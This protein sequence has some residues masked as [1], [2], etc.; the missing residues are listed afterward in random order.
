LSRRLK[1]SHARAHDERDFS[2][3]AKTHLPKKR[4]T[5]NIVELKD[6]RQPKKI[7]LLPKNLAQESYIDALEDTSKHI[8]FAAGPAGT[9]KTMLATLAGIDQLQKN[10]ISKIIITRPAVSVDEQHGFLPGTLVEKMQPWVLPILDYFYQH[11]SKKEVLHLIDDGVIEIAPLAYMRGRT[12]TG[13]W[14]IGDEMQNATPSQMKMLCTRIGSGSKL[15]ITGD[16]T[17]HDRGFDHNGL[18]DI[19]ARFNGQ[20]GIAVCKFSDRDVER[21]PIIETIL[22]MYGDE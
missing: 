18:K 7:V 19:M 11:Y 21:H 10:E 22:K 5:A 14:I 8:V 12:F 9:G 16:V 4:G 15:V 17:Q 2:T 13:A 20:E 1:R 3:N 6:Y